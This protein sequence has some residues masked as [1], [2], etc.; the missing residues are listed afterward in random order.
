MTDDI[1]QELRSDADRMGHVY[2]IELAHRGADEIE[3]LRAAN[4]AWMNGVADAVEPL[5]YD[6][7]AA[8]GPADL[9][10]GLRDLHAIP[11]GVWRVTVHDDGTIEVAGLLEFNWRLR[12]A[13]EL[14]GDWWVEVPTEPEPCG[15]RGPRIGHEGVPLCRQPKGHKGPHRPN[16]EDGWGIVTWPTEPEDGAR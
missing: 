7:D 9:L 13:D 15:S 1:V 12:T 16:D 14:R 2:R 11:P 10:P 8:C 5:G 6:R 3:R 4:V